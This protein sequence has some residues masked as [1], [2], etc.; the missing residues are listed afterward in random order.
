MTTRL[1]TSKTTEV[2]MSIVRVDTTLGLLSSSFDSFIAY[3][4]SLLFV[5]GLT[6][7]PGLAP[8][9]TAAGPSALVQKVRRLHQF[10]MQLLGLLDPG[11]VVFA[12]HEGLV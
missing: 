6:A 3:F 1:N 12:G 7:A 8:G 2:I 9:T 10:V 5:G 4:P 11:A